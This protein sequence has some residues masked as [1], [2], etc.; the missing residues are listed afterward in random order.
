MKKMRELFFLL[1]MVALT[2]CIIGIAAADE[3][4]GPSSDNVRMHI[5]VDGGIDSTPA[6]N[7][8]KLFIANW[9]SMDF[10]TTKAMGISCYNLTDGDRIWFR[11]IGE[12]VSGITAAD[13]QVFA[14][15]KSGALYC[16]DEE[17]G[18]TMWNVSGIVSGNYWGLTSTPL[19][20]N[21]VVY[22]TSPTRHMLF[23]YDV[24][25]GN[26]VF[27]QLLES[28]GGIDFTSP[29]LS[30]SNNLL[31]TNGTSIIEVSPANGLVN[32]YNI[33]SGIT[34]GSSI[35]VHGNAV[36]LNANG[37]LYRINTNGEWTEA[38]NVSTRTS[39]TPVV[40]DSAVYVS[41]SG[42][43]SAYNVTTGEA[44]EGFTTHISGGTSGYLNP[45]L[46]GNTVYYAMNAHQGK[47]FAI[48][49]TTGAEEWN[50][51]L[52]NSENAG[53]D[54]AFFASSPVV[55]D[56]NLFIG[57]EGA[58]FYVI[59]EGNLIEVDGTNAVDQPYVPQSSGTVIY[60][61]SVTLTNTSAGVTVKDALDA[62]VSEG[63]F[64]Y[65]LT[66]SNT[67]ADING[68]QNADDW[69]QTWMTNYYNNNE[70][71]VFSVLDPIIAGATISLH[72]DEFDAAWNV[73]GT[74]YLVN[75]TV[76]N[77][78]EPASW[79]TIYEDSIN[80]TNTSTGVTV[81]D[82]LDAAVSAGGFTYNLTASNTIADINGIQNADDWS[83]T[84]MTNYYN[85][86]ETP[87][88]SV[89]DPIIAGA[90]ISLHYDEFDA[91][92]NVVGTEYLVNVTVSNIV[93][94]ASWTTIYED[95]INLTNTST[96]VTVKD[97][98]DAA[99][100]AGGFTY[101]L[102][103]SN[104]IADIN[105]IQNAD[106]WSHTWMTTYYNN[107]DTDVY[108]VNDSV[109]SGATISLHYDEFNTTSWS[110][111]GT[112]YIVNVTVSNIV[113]PTP[114]TGTQGGS[115]PK[116]ISYRTITVQPGSFTY[117]T[118]EDEKQITVNNQSVFGILFES[119][120]TLQTKEWPGGIYVYSINGIT[121]DENLNGWLYQVNGMTTSQ[122]S[123]NYIT[124]DGDKIV[125]YYSDDMTATPE[126]SNNVYGFTVKVNLPAG[127]AKTSGTAAPLLNLSPSD[128]PTITLKLPEGVT[129]SGI[130]GSQILTIDT[131]VT[132]V[133][134]YV[135]VTEN[136][137]II[138][139]P[140][141]QITI[142][143]ETPEWN[144]DTVTARIQSVTA[145]LIPAAVSVKTAGIEI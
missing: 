45:V 121:Q 41:Q 92:W 99:V 75:V 89:L 138:T 86:N 16:L 143:I 65:N 93:E 116:S 108:S 62:A 95:S 43:L 78:V 30:S 66:A 122:M 81:K 77:I 79:T 117:R 101:N 29:A 120:K 132:K 119:G 71:P 83:Q 25:N 112:E 104:T 76:S 31:M 22:V 84:W 100:S 48:N 11:S 144:G 2:V 61:G 128:T 38:W 17:T 63:G 134:G 60:N 10:Y 87:V 73:V 123:N 125:W 72:Y 39:T 47:V 124:Q 20:N 23:G 9:K 91:A 64:S 142:L 46:A 32:S 67:I 26:L 7:D 59:G 96:G 80:L 37:V 57:S 8:S 109:I 74:E 110:V 54:Y 44:L 107:N 85:N 141:L 21:G 135:N 56:D 139:T 13:G 36:Y 113:E 131:T 145:E 14:G 68:I 49:A 94:P 42:N 15:T 19:V 6:V 69:S 12:V 127:I 133:S 115:T 1:S 136:S 126:T 70:T 52:P 114:G 103:A 5:S 58:G 24:S 129:I 90:T 98:L 51:S 53:E 4:T 40:T 137:I 33:S 130:S 106:D 18:N 27:Q 82:A 28:N 35:V 34:T 88:F 102:T 111:L 3:P 105:G 55:Y 118:T 50:F 97:A 140:G